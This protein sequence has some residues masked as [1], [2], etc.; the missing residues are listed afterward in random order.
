[1]TQHGE[2]VP[3]CFTAWWEPTTQSYIQMKPMNKP[4]NRQ[5]K[6]DGSG[7]A[8]VRSSRE[9]G[10]RDPPTGSLQSDVFLTFTWAEVAE[11]VVS[12]IRQVPG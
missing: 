6:R 10:Q 8:V 5:V 2:T 1:M 4:A 11:V 7:A 3:V 9:D 12:T